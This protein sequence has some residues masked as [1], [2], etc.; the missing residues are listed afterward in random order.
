VRKELQVRQVI[1]GGKELQVKQMRK[2]LCVNPELQVRPGIQVRKDLQ[3]RQERQRRQVI[4][5]R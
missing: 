3:V 5:G 4:P 2:N 1:Q